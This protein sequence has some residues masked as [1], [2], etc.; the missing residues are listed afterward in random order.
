MSVS[1]AHTAAG[2]PRRRLAT[3]SSVAVLVAGVLSGCGGSSGEGAVAVSPAGAA[4]A[5]ALT[6][7]QREGCATTFGYSPVAAA[8]LALVVDLT[9]SNVNF[10]LS[11][12]L[13]EQLRALSLE[14]GALTVI[15]IDGGG[16]APRVILDRAGLS[17]EKTGDDRTA[18]SVTQT[19]EYI[20]TCVAAWVQEKTRP[21]ADGTD[22]YPALKAA[23]ESLDEHTRGIWMHSDFQINVGPMS[24]MEQDLSDLATAPTLAAALAAG[25]P[26]DLR[27]VP[28]H[29]TGVANSLP[30]LAPQ[31]RDWTAEFARGLC[32]AWKAEPSSCAAITTKPAA[33][34]RSAPADLPGDD[35]LPFPA[36]A[37]VSMGTRCQ[38]TVPGALTFAGDTA[39]VRPDGAASMAAPLAL[40]QTNPGATA[41]ITGHTASSGGRSV[42][43]L[44]ELSRSRAE[45]TKGLLVA[46]GIAVERITTE[47][48]GDT[49]PLS[50]D[51]D[52][53]T[54]QQVP[55]LAAAERR[56]TI[57]VEGV[58]CSG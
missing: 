39:T 57:T 1:R 56:V 24:L 43:Q 17:P 36:V 30:A 18:P 20:P 51:I 29:A 47:G 32:T 13:A 16:A 46:S 58:P 2:S 5:I 52:P 34:E 50:E 3:S 33:A 11:E 54:G 26:L 37:A 49:Q 35:P 25:A 19:A 12:A 14:G 45:A 4:S 42:S 44:L 9:R 7:A 40:L 28:F 23:A 38:F 6:E 21:T 15:G 41:M 48:V 8:N 27:G 22:I 31:A 53:A 10:E 55:A